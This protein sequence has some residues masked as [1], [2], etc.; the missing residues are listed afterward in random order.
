MSGNSTCRHFLALMRK[1]WIIYKRNP[2]SACI[3]IVAPVLFMLLIVWLRSIVTADT[4]DTGPLIKLA[5]PSFTVQIKND[6]LSPITSTRLTADFFEF[7]GRKGIFGVEYEVLQDPLS[8]TYF[9]PPNC[10]YSND[11]TVPADL[12]AVVGANNSVSVAVEEYM[13]KLFRDQ[14]V[15]TTSSWQPTFRHFESQEALFDYIGGP[16]YLKTESGVCF[17]FEIAQKAADSWD[18]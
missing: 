3:Q 5:H 7:D 10:A 8:P 2:C 14:G 4:I 15:L 13:R 12:V 9:F 6:A 16:D 1:N 11:F 17:G 18:V